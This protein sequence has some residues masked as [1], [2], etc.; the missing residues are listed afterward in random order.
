M[1]SSINSPQEQSTKHFVEN[2]SGPKQKG[3]ASTISLLRKTLL[4]F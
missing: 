3:R 2:L 1:K 4:T